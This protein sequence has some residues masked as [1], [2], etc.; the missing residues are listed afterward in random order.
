MLMLY[1][2]IGYFVVYYLFVK[3]LQTKN[4]GYKK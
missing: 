3:F 4:P 1:V 2:A